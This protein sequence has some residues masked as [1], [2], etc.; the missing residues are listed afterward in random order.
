MFMVFITLAFKAMDI[1]DANYDSDF[2]G[3]LTFFFQFIYLQ[4][5]INRSELLDEAHQELPAN[6]LGLR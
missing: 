2:S 3:I 4:Y 5:K 6:V 1:L